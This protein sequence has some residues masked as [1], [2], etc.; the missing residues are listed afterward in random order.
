MEKFKELGL[1]K[2]ILSILEE[3]K[4]HVPSEIQEK[5]LPLVLKGKDV[6]GESATG[7]GKTLVFALP[8]VENLIPKIKY[9]H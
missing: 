2:E 5:T 8:I 4:F 7:S 9:K 3:A 1:S 6:I